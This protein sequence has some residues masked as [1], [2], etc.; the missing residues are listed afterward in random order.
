VAEKKV[1]SKESK[2]VAPEPVVEVVEIQF[3]H[4]NT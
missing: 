2:E 4:L 3:E 1:S